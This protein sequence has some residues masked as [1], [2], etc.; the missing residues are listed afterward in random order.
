VEYQGAMGASYRSGIFCPYLVATYLS[1]QIKPSQKKFLIRIPG[2]EDLVTAN[3]N[4]YSNSHNW[5]MAV[6]G[7]LLMGEKG[8]LSIESRFINQNGIDAS[9]EIRF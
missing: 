5:G 6:G 4:T 9:L 1:A 2:M 3:T 7:T 8:T